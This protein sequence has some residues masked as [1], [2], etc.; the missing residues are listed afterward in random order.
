MC[1]IE[2]SGAMEVCKACGR[3]G[4]DGRDVGFALV[5]TRINGCKWV[6]Q[7]VEAINWV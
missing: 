4:D 1:Q 3:A 7:W 6:K 5:A 2:I